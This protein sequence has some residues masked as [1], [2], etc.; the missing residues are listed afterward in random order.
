MSD[1]T[2]VI[3]LL[4]FVLGGFALLTRFDFLAKKGKNCE[5]RGR[6]PGT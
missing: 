3:L 6:E 2:Y 4:V 1:V 5:R